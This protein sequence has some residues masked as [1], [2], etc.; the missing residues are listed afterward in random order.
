MHCGPCLVKSPDKASR[1]CCD[2]VQ[3]IV[4]PASGKKRASLLDGVGLRGISLE[5]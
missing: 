4:A 3:S 1:K 2:P 5:R